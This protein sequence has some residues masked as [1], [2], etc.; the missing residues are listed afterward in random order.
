[1]LEP[2][3]AITDYI[4]AAQGFCFAI[5]IY[6]KSIN[7][8][9]L[10]LF[11]SLA[12]ASF[13]GGTVHGFFSD[14]SSL[15]SSLLWKITLIAIGA[16]ALAGWH[17]GT[18]F[19]RNRHVAWWIEKIAFAQFYFFTAFVLFYS[20]QFFLAALN[21]LPT[22]IFLLAIFTREYHRKKLNAPLF[23]A[24]G[25]VLTFLGTSVQF[26]KIPLHPLYFN[27]NALYHAI[28]FVATC[29]LF[30]TA[31]WDITQGGKNQK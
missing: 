9:W 18:A 21:Y 19:L 28:Q 4:L 11:G 7:L 30:A 12:V 17:V 31:Q 24:F 10:L 1:M 29:L 26:A 15:I 3:V 25:I 23:G 20:Q 6:R 2:D 8:P 16:V 13:T 5:L 14:E 27:H 22:A